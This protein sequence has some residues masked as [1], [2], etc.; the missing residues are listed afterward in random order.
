MKRFFV[1]FSRIPRGEISNF[2]GESSSP[3][4]NLLYFLLIGTPGPPQCAIRRRPLRREHFFRHTLL[5]PICDCAAAPRGRI[6]NAL[7]FPIT[8]GAGTNTWQPR[9]RRPGNQE[10]H[11]RGVALWCWG[12]RCDYDAGPGAPTGAVRN[13][14]S[15][16]ALEQAH[17]PIAP[18]WKN[19]FLKF[20]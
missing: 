7:C 10:N 6:G 20:R 2:C 8:R 3:A 13:G 14:G 9:S 15:L 4:A 1:F 12:A 19:R 16:G 18:K 5:P 17:K 11:A